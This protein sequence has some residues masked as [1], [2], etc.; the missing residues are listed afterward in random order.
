M[1]HLIQA[2]RG[3]PAAETAEAYERAKVLAK[4]VGSKSL[5]LLAG[6]WATA[7]GRGELRAALALTE[8]MLDIANGIGSSHALTTA[9]NMQGNTRYYLGDLIGARQHFLLAIEHYRE[10]DFLGNPTDLG[11]PSLVWAGANEWQLGYPGRSLGY[12][13]DAVSLARRQNKPLS[14]ILALTARGVSGRG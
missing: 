12:I 11:V 3:Y 8:Q 4:R 2:T 10:E 6:L 5:Q 9:H 14:L 7:N 13:G 1:G